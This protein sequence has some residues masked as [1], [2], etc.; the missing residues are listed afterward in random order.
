VKTRVVETEFVFDRYADTDLSVAYAILVPQRRARTG[1]R[2]QEGGAH[3]DQRGDL[4][5]GVFSPAE[6][7]RDDRIPDGGV[8]RARQAAGA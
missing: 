3:D 5:P 4:R 6:E 8:A 1:Q 7:R 2:G